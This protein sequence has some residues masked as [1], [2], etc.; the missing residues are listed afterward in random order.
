MAKKSITLD[1][2]H[3]QRLA[4]MPLAGRRATTI[5]ENSQLADQ[6]DNDVLMNYEFGPSPVLELADIMT[7]KGATTTINNDDN[8]QRRQ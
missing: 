1:G 5:H 2:Q 6:F 4:V 8:K 7:T 3:K